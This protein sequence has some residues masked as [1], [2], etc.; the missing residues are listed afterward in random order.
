ML[1]TI[2][3]EILLLIA[4]QLSVPRDVLH[5][6]SCCHQFH[7]LLTPEAYSTLRLK[8]SSLLHLTRLTHT[9]ARNLNLASAVR[10][11]RFTDDVDLGSSQYFVAHYDRDTIY[12][13]LEAATS[14]PD[15]LAAWEK[16]LAEKHDSEG[17]PWMAVLL[18][19]LP[20][21]EELVMTVHYPSL[22]T[23][24]MIQRATQNPENTILTKLR[25]ITASW[26]DTENGLPSSYVLPFFRLPSLR[27]FT[28]HMIEDGRFED[29]NMHDDDPD[30]EIYEEEDHEIK[31]EKYYAAP[32]NFS[33]VTH[34]HL[35]NSNSARGLP[36]LIGAAKRLESFV[37]MYNG[38]VGEYD[39]FDP[40]AFYKSLR[41]H[42]DSLQ[43]ITLC[44]TPYAF[45]VGDPLEFQFIGSFADF[46][47]LKS[48]RL[49]SFNILRWNEE[50][51]MGST[52][53]LFDVLPPSLNSLTIED[54][55]KHDG[56]SLLAQ[57]EDLIRDR[58]SHFPY[59]K[60]LELRGEMREPV[61]D[62]TPFMSGVLVARVEP[63]RMAGEFLDMS[64]VLANLCREAGVR[65]LFGDPNIEMIEMSDFDGS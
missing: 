45:S 14:S 24:R 29:Q 35:Y 39:P 18:P 10:S 42:K 11:L 36:D 28:G 27:R 47:A 43:E 53:S 33:N 31:E 26:W 21:L 48:L 6:A 64:K 60:H 12:P 9:L 63:L 5:L 62:I 46:T 44:E 7:A 13:L 17:D 59:L 30:Y 40:P 23:R 58:K 56:P 51:A 41:K 25:D 3:R 19:L 57:L 16:L 54:F 37:Y 1:S 38:S 22:Y 34:L 2:P 65:F 55:N 61:R 50:D 4:S 49:R 8:D 52:N 15:E 20:N 32:G